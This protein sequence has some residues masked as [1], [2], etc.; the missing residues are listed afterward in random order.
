MS[1]EAP[2]LALPRIR[3]AFFTRAGGVSEGIYGSLNGGIGSRDD[4]AHVAENRSRMADT[5]GVAPDALVS[6]YQVHSADAVIVDRPWT[7]EER[8]RA[9]GMATATPNLAIAIATADCGPVLFADSHA[10]VVGA[11]HAGWKGAL[12]GVLE[13]TVARMEE[14]GAVRS[15]I[16]AVLGPTIGPDNYEVGPERQ[17]CFVEADSANQRFFRP[18][19]SHQGHLMFD[20]PGYIV[21][22]LRA[23]GLRQAESLGLC[24]Y[25]DDARFYSYRRTTH[26]AEP[27]YG[28]LISAIAVTH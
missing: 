3:H 6:L 7:P 24:T 16:V 11:C 13:S 25:A 19:T 22:R 8:P 2:E 9:D 10:G 14:L 4:P 23:A 17:A 1:I 27:D 28:R 21:A 18:S 5:L 15:Q 26:R 20:L 12:G